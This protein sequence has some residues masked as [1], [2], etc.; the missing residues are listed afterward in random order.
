MIHEGVRT[1]VPMLRFVGKYI[2]PTNIDHTPR[3]HPEA[4][5]DLPSTFGNTSGSGS[6]S[7]GMTFAQYRVNKT[8]YGPLGKN[9]LIVV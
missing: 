7:S 8:Q 1:Y 2:R 9:M 3:R 5:E 6:G 4:T